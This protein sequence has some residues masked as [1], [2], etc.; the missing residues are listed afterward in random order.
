MVLAEHASPRTGLTWPGRKVLADEAEVHQREVEVAL[1][2]LEASGWIE[3]VSEPG[4]GRARRWRFGHPDAVVGDARQPDD[5]DDDSQLSGIPD[6]F[7]RLQVVGEVVGEVV[8]D[9]RHE[10]EPEPSAICD[11]TTTTARVEP[12]PSSSIDRSVLELIAEAITVAANPERRKW[13]AFRRSVERNLL[14]E[15]G[16]ELAARLAAGETGHLIAADLAGGEVYA[17]RAARNLAARNLAAGG[18]A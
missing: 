18:A 7:R 2:V 16:T 14:D 9:P 6:T 1:A 17:S 3:R 11:Q 13:R 12:T 8:G 10:P 15:R 5:H 4:R